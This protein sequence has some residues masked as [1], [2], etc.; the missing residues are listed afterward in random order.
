MMHWKLTYV[1]RSYGITEDE[2]L[3]TDTTH[4]WNLDDIESDTEAAEKAK[5]FLESIIR[6]N[7][8][9]QG[10]KLVRIV[11]EEVTVSIQIPGL[12]SYSELKWPK[13]IEPVPHT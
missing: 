9:V 2:H 3:W 7:G 11:Q 10:Y 8:S 4:T 12:K 13:K 5:A 6:R 1:L